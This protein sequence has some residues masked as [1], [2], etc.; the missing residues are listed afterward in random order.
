MTSCSG[1]NVKCEM[2]KNIFSKGRNV[3]VRVVRVVKSHEIVWSH[4]TC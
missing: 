1:Y 4:N 3:F 2:F